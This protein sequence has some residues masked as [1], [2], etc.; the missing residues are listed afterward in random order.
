MIRSETYRQNP[1]KSAQKEMLIKASLIIDSHGNEE[2]HLRALQKE[3]MGAFFKYLLI[4][5]EVFSLLVLF[6]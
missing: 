5:H 1:K 4:F 6:N 3:R 2:I